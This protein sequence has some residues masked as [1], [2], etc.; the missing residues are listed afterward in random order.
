MINRLKEYISNTSEIVWKE[1]ITLS[2][3]YA[4]LV[5]LI[6]GVFGYGLLYNY[7]YAPN[8]IRKAPVAVVDLSQTELSRKFIRY[9][10]ASSQI[11]IVATDVSYPDAINMMDESKTIGV[12]YIPSDFDTRVSQGEQ[13]IFILYESTTVFLSFM[14][15]QE[16]SAACMLAINDFYRP[17]MLVF[18]D[19]SNA[20]DLTTAQPINVE[21]TALYNHTE[22]YGSYLIPAVLFVIIFQTLMMIIAM[23][24]GEE[25]NT[26]SILKYAGDPASLNFGR[27]AQVVFGKSI[28]YLIIYSLL[29]VFF[30]G[31]IPILFNLPRIGNI[32]DTMI[33][34]VPYILASSF[35]GL[36]LSIL[37]TD[38]DAPIVM[39]AFF[40]VGLIFLSGV[41]YPLELQPWYWRCA[42]FIIP[43]GS[44]TLAYVMIN[45]MGSS[46]NQIAIEYIALWIQCIVYFITACFVLRFNIRKAMQNKPITATPVSVHPQADF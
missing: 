32:L 22:G 37:Y 1:L 26:R 40:S 34:F 21:G 39:I 23:I 6:G 15:L 31:L 33:L 24:S 28:A 8:L 17:E 42:H 35:F 11:D 9:M 36:T 18:L 25:R 7:M 4:V 10:D 45:S 3:N 27:M 29:C 16:A 41:S 2:T 20:M 19:S 12:L 30:L 38:G 5:V 13:S 46:I 14:A 43:A 44:G